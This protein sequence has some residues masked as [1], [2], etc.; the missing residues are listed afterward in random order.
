MFL[1]NERAETFLKSLDSPFAIISVAG[2]YRTGKSFLINRMFLNQKNGFSVGPSVNP[3]TKG[4]WIWSK[5]IVSSQ[6]D[7]T[8][9]NTLV[10]DTEGFGGGIDEDQNH[11]IKIFTLAILLSSFF[12][13]NSSGIIDETS[14]NSLNFIINLTKF[15]ELKTNLNNRVNGNNYLDELSEH[16]PSF[17]WVLRDFS[18]QLVND[19]KEN[20]PPKEYMEKVLD[21]QSYG[22]NLQDNDSKN[23]VRKMIKTFFKDR[24]CFTLIRPFTNEKQLQNNDNIDQLRSEFLEQ[25]NVLKTKILNKIK[26]KNLKGKIING[27][28]Y[29]QIIKYNLYK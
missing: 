5:P 3:C 11:D 7:G 29:V 2:V 17:L 21:N 25:I 19:N 22:I 9:L 12:I 27:E 1:L 6:E 8:S 16:F 23:R 10:I 24:D 15:L 20:M 26:P 14:L 13:Y 4:L 18:L 28:M